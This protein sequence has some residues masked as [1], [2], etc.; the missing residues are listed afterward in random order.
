MPLN[1]LNEKVSYLIISHDKLIAKI[2]TFEIE[3]AYLH[4]ALDTIIEILT[5]KL[6][7][8]DKIMRVKGV[9]ELLEVSRSTVVRL[10]EKE[11]L[12]CTHL[13]GIPYYLQSEVFDVF[14]KTKDKEQK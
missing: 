7:D 1:Q 11:M 9:M 3:Y 10:T 5:S 13:E 8:A 12:P 2:N 6:P 14:K 4:K